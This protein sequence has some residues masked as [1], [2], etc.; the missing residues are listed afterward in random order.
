M[1]AG[2]LLRTGTP[3]DAE[4]L[5]SFWI[6]AAENQGRPADRPDDIRQL[7]ERDP[8]AL[9]IADA[10]GEIVGSLIVGWD[11]W[12]FHL[13]RLAVRPDWRGRR[14]GRALVEEAER[15]CMRLGSRRIDAMVLEGNELGVGFWEAL[16]YTLQPDWRRWVRT[17]T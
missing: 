11:G 10:D 2:Y 15:Y 8:E 17:L 14:V 4:S 1:E 7:L 12:R 5:V 13:Y 16:G 6:D 3:D 9:F